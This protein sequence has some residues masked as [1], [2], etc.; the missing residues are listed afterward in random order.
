ME[1]KVDKLLVCMEKMCER[2]INI[3]KE[4]SKIKYLADL[5]SK[6]NF[7]MN[8]NINKEMTEEEKKTF[9]CKQK[10]YVDKLNSGMIKNPK[11]TTLEYYKVIPGGDDKYYISKDVVDKNN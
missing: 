3:E 10:Q 9:M 1:D 8:N 7:N 6:S 4:I 11:S 2:F 5:K